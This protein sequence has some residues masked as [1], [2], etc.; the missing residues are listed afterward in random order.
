MH[1]HTYTKCLDPKTDLIGQR[2]V[3]GT[4][5]REGKNQNQKPTVLTYCTDPELT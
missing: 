1:P 4:A 5:Y 2:S 3:D